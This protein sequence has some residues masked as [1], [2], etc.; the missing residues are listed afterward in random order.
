MN[1]M[2]LK[3]PFLLAAFFISTA[4]LAACGGGGGGSPGG[5][6]TTP[7]PPMLTTPAAAPAPA[8]VIAPAPVVAPV[9]TPS[10]SGTEYK[11]NA[12][13]ALIKPEAAWTRGATGAGITVAVI[14]SGVNT[15][16]TDLAGRVTAVDFTSGRTGEPTSDHGTQVAGVIA[17]GFNGAFTVGVAYEANILGLRVDEAGTCDDECKFNSHDIALALDY[18]RTHGARVV[19][20][21]LGN[22]TGSGSEARAAM[23]RAVDAGMVIVAS[24]GND[25]AADPGFPARYAVDARYAGALIAA[26]ALNASGSDLASFSDRAGV[27]KEGYLAAPGQSIRT[28][29]TTTSSGSTCSVVS[30]TSFAAPH[31][32]GALALLLDGFP[33]ITGRDAVD[34]LLRSARDMG[35]PGTDTTFG[36]GAL[37][38]ER[39]FQPIGALS[40]PTPQGSDFVLDGTGSAA[41]AG[42]AFGDAL[43]SGGALQTV[44]YDDYRRLYQ[45][46]LGATWRSAARPNPLPASTPAGSST[47]VSRPLEGGGALRVAAF[48]GAPERVSP[49]GFGLAAGRGQEATAVSLSKGALRLDLWNGRGGMQP[50]FDGAPQDA[51]TTLAQAGQAVRAGLA[52]GRWT[53]SAESGSGLVDPSSNLDLL[54]DPAATRAPSQYGRAVGAFVGESWTVSVGAGALSEPA[55]PLGSLAPAHSTFAMPAQSRFTSVQTVWR[56]APGLQLSAQ[57][58]FGR[59]DADGALMHLADARTSSWALA[60]DIACAQFGIGGCQGVTFSLSQPLRIE[61]GEISAML[62]D[63]PLDYSD[64][65]TFSQRTLALSPSARELDVGLGLHRR[66]AAGVGR[67]QATA[68]IN[69]GHRADAAVAYGLSASFRTRF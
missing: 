9:A 36:R 24:A 10:I 63:V 43:I 23:K 33:N 62:A 13:L 53:F 21:S 57:A 7:A 41:S 6:V 39:A 65:I 54:A 19:N 46:N 15:G 34:I 42:A 3:R 29:C 37:D 69:P 2:R 16:Q 28:N 47:E 20:M 1:G 48:V 52:L 35:E 50:A 30:G 12:G 25:G 66:I 64:P 17:S 56:G 61:A 27:A 14:D 38:I 44:G 8:P 26:G 45:V 68:L 55:G 60:A 4:P 49:V 5:G 67:L 18:A 32:A 22:D 11:R 58:A 59:T 31:I 51:F 40:S